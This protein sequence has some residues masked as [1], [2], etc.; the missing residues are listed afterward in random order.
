MYQA[1]SLV[2]AYF[3][4]M[5]D[6]VNPTLSKVASLIQDILPIDVIPL[7]HSALLQ[8]LISALYTELITKYKGCAQKSVKFFS[9]QTT[10]QEENSV[11]Q[12]R[13]LKVDGSK[14]STS[15]D[16][17]AY[18]ADSIAL[19]V[20]EALC[21]IDEDNKHTEQ[22]EEFLNQVKIDVE[23]NE[24]L[25]EHVPLEQ[26]AVRLEIL[27]SDLLMMQYGKST[28]KVSSKLPNQTLSHR[29]LLNQNRHEIRLSFS[30]QQKKLKIGIW[31]D[32]FICFFCCNCMLL[33]SFLSFTTFPL[34]SFSVDSLSLH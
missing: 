11:N 10:V 5:W 2:L 15:L 21:S 24:A 7:G 31:S 29:D 26:S 34:L 19:A 20:A 27:A 25:N 18:S 22:I 30:C 14:E 17:P 4:Q 8:I 9:D 3:A 16:G 13:D 6:C 12:L 28:L 32:F 33:V 1:M 23:M